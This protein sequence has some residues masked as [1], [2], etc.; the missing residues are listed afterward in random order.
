M[1]PKELVDTINLVRFVFFRAIKSLPEVASFRALLQTSPS[2][3]EHMEAI[4]QVAR[5]KRLQEFCDGHISCA[6]IGSSGHGKTTIL[7]EMFP[8][9]SKRGW[10]VTDVTDT[11]SQALRIQFAPPKTKKLARVLVHSWN[12]EQIKELLTHQEVEQQNRRD[13]IRVTW[14]ENGAEVDGTEANFPEGDLEQFRFPRKVDL[15][16]FAF[17]YEVDREEALDRT[18]IRALTVK[19]QSQVMRTGPVLGVDG[20]EYNALQLRAVVKDVTLHDTFRQVR[21]WAGLSQEQASHLT[22]VDTPGLAVAGSVKDEVLR[23]MLEKKSEQIAVQLWKEDELD[24]L[25]HLVLVGRQS[26]FSG[27]WKAIERECGP[28]EMADLADR[29]ILAVNGMNT[30]FTNRDIMA[31]YQ[32]PER[33]RREG[34]HFAT[35]LE[36][37]ILQKM[38]PRG[39]IQPAKICFLDSRS[40]V[41]TLTTGMYEE[42]YRRYLPIMESWMKP[43][44]IGQQTLKNLGILHDFRENVEALIDPSDRGQGFLVRQICQLIEKKGPSLLIKKYFLRTGLISAIEDLL[45]LIGLYYDREGRLN[46]QAVEEALRSCLGFLDVRDPFGVDDFVAETI[47]PELDALAEGA[48]GGRWGDTTEVEGGWIVQRFQQMCELVKRTIL[49]RGQPSREVAAEFSRHFDTQSAIWLERWGYVTAKLPP[50]DRGFAASNP[51]ITH[52]LKLHAREILYQLLQ[53]D[54]SDGDAAVFRQSEDDRHQI[55]DLVRML[56]DA[57]R[58]GVAACAENGVRL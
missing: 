12:A 26:D 42:A 23:H 47:D 40:I 19:E 57:Y 55:L 30:Y 9:L 20:R 1:I 22:F 29:M 48:D 46:R 45:D 32:D 51:L 10:L 3:R 36:D 56:E 52:C 16:P 17:P 43:G 18:F 13:N 21:D 5:A 11:T 15:R 53:D 33:A 25:V 14:L 50:P 41:E 27:L 58:S 35:T 24:I 4:R 2:A 39:R 44:G 54:H 6:F 49:E 28:G 37:N 7:D 38:S 31:K 34:D 8:V